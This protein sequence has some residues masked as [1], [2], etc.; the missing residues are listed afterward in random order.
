MSKI[1]LPQEAP[2]FCTP[3][4]GEMV[5]GHHDMAPWLTTEK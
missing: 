4:E 2:Q 1:L 3:L 5:N